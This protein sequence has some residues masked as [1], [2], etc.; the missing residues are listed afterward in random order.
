M[1]NFYYYDTATGRVLATG[2]YEE[3][4]DGAAARAL[5][6]GV[7]VPATEYAPGGVKTA[8]PVFAPALAIDKLTILANAVDGA[9]ITNIPAGTT[10]KIYKDGDSLPRA[11]ILINDGTLLLQADSA[12]S[13]QIV[14][15]K[16]PTQDTT[17]T[18]S[19]TS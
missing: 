14:F 12:G 19:A 5:G 1:I 3:R 10:A 13:Y 18:V 4:G 9:T 6:S 2:G 16:F 11:A 17:F 15:S 7:I 8:R